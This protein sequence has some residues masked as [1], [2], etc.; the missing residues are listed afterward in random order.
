L[1]VTIC[2]GNL[3]GTTCVPNAVN[4]TQQRQ[5]VGETRI[6]GIQTDAEYRLGTQWRLSGGYLFTD[7]KVTDGGSVP[8]LEG[9]YLQQVP[10]HRGSFQVGYAD[11]RYVNVT[12]GVQYVG[13]QFD[14]DLN[15]RLVPVATLTA[16]GYEAS[17]APGIP[18]YMVAG[19]TVS[20]AIGPNLE[21]FFGVQNIGDR[22]Y[23][24]GTLP[25]TIGSPRLVNGGI[26]VRFSAR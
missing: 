14:D 26:R 24:V 8:A 19:L 6:R 5:N 22:E 10:K 13:L 1:N 16:A 20:R 15:V 21:A 7:A 2:A 17:T 3:S 4:L 18:G 9:T 12:F 25:S 23:F 11:P